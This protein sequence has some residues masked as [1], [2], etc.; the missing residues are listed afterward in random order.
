MSISDKISEEKGKDTRT[1]TL[2]AIAD[3]LA[4]KN[5][6]IEIGRAHV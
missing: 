4:S 5:I 1:K 2:G 6:D 3:L